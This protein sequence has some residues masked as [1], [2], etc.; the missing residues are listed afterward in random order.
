MLKPI[1]FSSLCL[2][3]T[4]SC[5]ISFHPPSQKHTG[6]CADRPGGSAGGEDQRFREF[7]DGASAQTQLHRGNVTAGIQLALNHAHF[8]QILLCT[9]YLTF[10]AG[11]K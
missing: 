3:N 9:K 2:E 11:T 7:F 1:L 5:P 6:E 10:I 8:C 4:S